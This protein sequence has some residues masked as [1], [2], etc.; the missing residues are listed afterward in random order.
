MNEENAND[1]PSTPYEAPTTDPQSGV[2]D[3]AALASVGERIGAIAIDIALMIVVGL[4][5]ILGIVIN[6]AYFLTKDCLPFLNG[7]SIGKK[8]LKIKAVTEDGQS[9]SGNWG[10]GIVRNVVMYIPFFGLVELI[11]LIVNKDKGM[12]RLGDQWAKT[13]VIKAG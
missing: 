7:Q 9:L 13:K 4:I 12:Q 1:A 8:A 5:P 6:I 10:A 3:N 2:T 11:M